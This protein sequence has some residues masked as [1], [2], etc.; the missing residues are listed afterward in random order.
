[1]DK[2]SRIA[3]IVALLVG[4]LAILAVAVALVVLL[5]V[6]PKVKE[7]VVA[8][9]RAR[10]IELGFDDIELSL[11]HVSIEKAR[12]RLIGVRGLAGTAERIDVTTKSF[13]PTGIHLETLHLELL[14]SVPSV[15]L[16]LSEW[17]KNYP[18]A[19]VLPLSGDPVS[20]RWRTTAAE[21]PWL[22]IGAGRVGR[23]E[24]GGEFEAKTAV[25][26]GVALGTVKTSWSSEASSIV[27]GFGEADLTRAPVTIDVAHK[28]KNPT[29]TIRLKPT[30]LE[31]LA[32]PLGVKLPVDDVTASAEVELTF[33]KTDGTGPVEGT[34]QIALDGYVPPHPPELNGFVFG[35]Q[36]T[37]QSKL[38]VNEERTRLGLSDTRTTPGYAWTS[39]VTWAAWR[40]P[41]PRR[42]HTLARPSPGSPSA[43][44]KKPC[45]GRWR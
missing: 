8:E 40:W 13:E 31:R 14:G 42:T 6:L 3:L 10:G 17:T 39:S 36:T 26:S 33:E 18:E 38:S 25:M 45:R 23:T 1:M 19:Y 37:F 32:G 2:K 21:K 41:A 22:V 24:N 20:V 9:A 15:A 12:F 28:K 34:I 7:R 11:S 35:K 44:S 4:T 27:L 30:P 16:E 43:S 29:A 5:V